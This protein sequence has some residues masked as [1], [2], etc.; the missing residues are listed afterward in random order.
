MA[1]AGLLGTNAS[2]SRDGRQMIVQTDK[3][4]VAAGDDPYTGLP[5]K[6][7]SAG[8]W[9]TKY[10]KVTDLGNLNG[11]TC[12]AGSQIGYSS[13]YGWAVDAT[14]KTAVGTAYIDRNGDGS[15]E[16]GYNDDGT[17]IG[18]EIVPFIWTAK[19]GMR[20]LS[21]N[22]VDLTT[23][24]WHRAQAISGDGRVVIGN[25]NFS[26]AYAWINEGDPIDLYK[27]IGA[28][29]GGYA[30]TPDASRVALETE[31]DGIVFWNANLGTQPEAFT[32]TQVLQWC[33]DL[34]FY[35]FGFSCDV[36][37]ADFIQSTFGPIPVYTSDMSDDGKVLIARAGTFFDSGFHGVMWVE[38][39]GWIKMQDFFRTQGVVEAYRYGLDGPASINGAG[40]EIVGG[41]PGVPQT[42]YVDMRNVF[43]CQNN[44]SVQ[45][46]FPAGFIAAVKAGA[47]M[48]RC[49]YQS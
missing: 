48:G 34:P 47:L 40:N 22:G 21:L 36:D 37:G 43:V 16:G 25:S 12:F 44:K 11:N 17:A 27:A 42:W 24:P 23:E 9:D 1:P 39:I 5:M 30:M 18:G 29:D 4:G 41:I 15:C 14:A 26:K 45:T 8:I 2:I 6:T 28:L 49:E 20:Q 33:V 32:K 3:H 10:G 19:G 7:N 31:H 13:S 46:D 38:D 35:D